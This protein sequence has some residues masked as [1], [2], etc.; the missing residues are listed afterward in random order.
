MRKESWVRRVNQ[1]R[2]WGPKRNIKEIDMNEAENE[3]DPCMRLPAKI[4]SE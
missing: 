2:G 3:C 1:N 4:P